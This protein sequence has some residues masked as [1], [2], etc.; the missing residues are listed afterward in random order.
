[1]K[2]M[3]S[4]HWFIHSF[5]IHTLGTCYTYVMLCPGHWGYNSE[6]KR[7]R[8]PHASFHSRSERQRCQERNSW[9]RSCGVLMIQPL[10]AYAYNTILH[11]KEKGTHWR[12]TRWMDFK[13][14]WCPVN[15]KRE[16]C[17]MIPFIGKVQEQTSWSMAINIRIT[18][19]YGSR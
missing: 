11:R 13:R 2:T 15:K 9:F 8:N 16:G 7:H 17:M 18:V 4:E 10:E 3:C 19:T 6:Q 14:N 12:Y 5:I 1:M